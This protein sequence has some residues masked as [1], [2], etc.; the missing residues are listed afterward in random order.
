[1]VNSCGFNPRKPDTIFVAGGEQSLTFF[2][3]QKNGDRIKMYKFKAPVTAARLSPNG[4][5]MAYALGND[6]TQGLNG[7]GKFDPK[8]VVHVMLEEDSIKKT[9]TI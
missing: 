2:T 1:M 5:Y 8:I 7:M 9:G 6:W 4:N 3:A